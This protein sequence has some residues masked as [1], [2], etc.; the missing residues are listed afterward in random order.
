M[1]IVDTKDLKIV[2]P[3]CNKETIIQDL[4]EQ[5]RNMAPGY[6]EG[7]IAEFDPLEQCDNCKKSFRVPITV[8]K[9]GNTL[10]VKNG[11]N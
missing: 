7:E 3:F 2:C 4:D 11:D 1:K 5:I 8:E 10:I 6:F 9:I